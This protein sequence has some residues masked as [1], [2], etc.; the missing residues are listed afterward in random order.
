MEVSKI[1]LFVGLVSLFIFFYRLI[2][3]MIPM[4]MKSLKEKDY[5]QVLNSLTLL[6]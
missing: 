2:I 5:G 4:F 1:E 6:V 3:V